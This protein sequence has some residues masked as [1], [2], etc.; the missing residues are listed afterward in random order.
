M[1]ILQGI[2]V[3]PG[4][5]IG[6]ALIFDQER[7][8][9]P[10]RFVMRD[11]VDSEWSRLQVAMDRVGEELEQNRHTITTQ[12]G[13]DYGA[14][15]AAHLQMLR[16][17]KLLRDLAELIR[18]RHYAPE[19]AVS[20]VFRR[21]AKVFQELPSPYWAERAHDVFDL[22]QRLLYRLVGARHEELSNLTSQVIVLAHDLTPSE[23][24]R[25]NPA[26]V[27]GFATEGGALGGHT[28]ILAKGLEIPAVVGTGSFLPHVSG[29]DWVIVDGDQGRVI[30]QPDAATMEAYR[31]EM[32]SRA[33]LVQ[34]LSELRCLPAE[35]LDG[36][37]IRLSANIEF[38]REVT[39][40]LQRGADGIGLY[41]TE[42]LYLGAD[43]EPSEEDHYAAYSQVLRE[44]AG[45]PVVFRTLDLGA[46]KL[47][48]LPSAEEERN[49]FLGL[50]SI[51]LALRNPH[52]FQ[53]QLR[54]LLRAS[55]LGPTRIMFP[56]IAT[57]GELRQAKAV[58]HG[59]MNDLTAAGVPFDRQ[60]PVGMMVEVPSAVVMLD[61]FLSEVDFISIGTNDLVQ[62]ALAVDR[63]NPVVAGLYQAADPAVLRL[64]EM[65]LQATQRADVPASVCGQMSAEGTYT[66][67]LLGLGLRELSVPPSSIPEIK[68]ICRAV[69][70][71]QCEQIAQQALT[72]DTATE[73]NAHLRRELRKVAPEL[74]V[75]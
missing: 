38:P 64:L 18:Q 11:A 17:P 61:K 22:E 58:L 70:I 21:Y 42:F 69:T 39:A 66:M 67:L 52:L 25:L 20:Q 8:R 14:I 41:R 32:R 24:A 35:T 7:I 15:F 59:V 65:S 23:T 33:H 75:A 30:C 68:R 26:F 47:G 13:A 40:C 72:L 9:I 2:A 60:L 74:M 63:S 50:R 73:V 12:L 56:L 4:I 48:Q 28:S 45:R 71:P 53:T 31:R 46:D 16:D 36:C 43:G 5:A 37:P 27:L 57:L 54:A 49:P 6:E 51:R 29:G 44:M 3:S 19:Y 55:M 62:Y 1:H 10:R 34:Q